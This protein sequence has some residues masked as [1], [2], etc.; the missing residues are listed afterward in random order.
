[1]ILDDTV[2]RRANWP[3]RL[4]LLLL[5]VLALPLSICTLRAESTSP[6]EKVVA[7]PDVVEQRLDRLEKMIETLASE[8][9]ESRN[10]QAQPVKPAVATSAS[11]PAVKKNEKT[12]SESKLQSA[13]G[14][15][16]DEELALL[17]RTA[18]IALQ[19]SMTSD[20]LSRTAEIQA[21]AMK[22][23]YEAGAVTVDQ[24]LEAQRRCAE[25]RTE[26]VRT[27]AGLYD[28]PGKR[29]YLLARG[30]LSA[31]NKALREAHTFW[32]ELHRLVTAG[33]DSSPAAKVEAQAREQY[34]QFKSQTQLH[35]GEVLRRKA[36]L[37][38][39]Y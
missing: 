11:S 38:A 14:G 32:A 28:N 9:R 24:V 20:K 17:V 26:Y 15:D 33:D 5:A 1:M 8:M 12:S 29:H 13:L 35:L 4:A 23:A 18:Q 3:L 36:A 7:K 30:A 25:A 22:T 2:I 10:L 19:R 27:V 6:N 39:G 21:E 37:D 16:V 31:S 34:F